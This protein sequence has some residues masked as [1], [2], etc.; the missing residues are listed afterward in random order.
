MLALTP[1]HHVH[2]GHDDQLRAHL[3]QSINDAGVAEIVAN[4]KTDLAPRRIP[5]LLLWC[6]QAVLE[7]LDR[8]AFTL[9]KNDFA[10][11]SDDECG[12]I[13]VVVRCRVFAADDEIA[14]MIAAPVLQ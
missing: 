7:K 14:L 12:V 13:E 9:A 6:R 1:I 2:S 10:G 4:A 11:R 5:K 3:D 8:H